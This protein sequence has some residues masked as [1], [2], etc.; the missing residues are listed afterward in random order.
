ME[1]FYFPKVCYDYLEED[2]FRDMINEILDKEF[3]DGV[4]YIGPRKGQ[5]A[6]IDA[7]FLK[8]TEKDRA[9]QYKWRE[10]ANNPAPRLLSE[11][12]AEFETWADSISKNE[13]V[14]E[15]LFITNISLT[16]TYRNRFQG[17]IRRHKNLHLEYWSF[18]EINYRLKKHDDL[19]YKYIGSL[20]PTLKEEIK[21]LKEYIDKID[22]R[23]L[24]KKSTYSGL[25]KLEEKFQILFISLELKKKYYFAFIYLLTPLYK[26][27]RDKIKRRKLRK[28]FRITKKEELNFINSLEKEGL[29]ELTGDLV[30]V[31]NKKKAEKILNEVINKSNVDLGKIVNLFF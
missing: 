23:K 20:V 13:N 17:V 21:E 8:P 28:L 18:E 3:K 9:I 2:G 26:G 10:I 27:E 1:K 15:G 14:G 5:D 25:K 22:K 12:F 29:I 4:F 30:T 31:A 11:V 16:K 7:Q 6:G 19:Y 24:L